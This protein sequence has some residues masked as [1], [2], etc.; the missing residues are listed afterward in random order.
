[1]STYKTR[2]NSWRN[3]LYVGMRWGNL[4]LVSTTVIIHKSPKGIH[5]PYLLVKDSDNN[6]REIQW[7]SLRAGYS[8]GKRTK[9]GASEYVLD[10]PTKENKHLRFT[11]HCIRSRCHNPKSTHY[12][13]YGG[14]GIHLQQEWQNNPNPFITYIKSLEGYGTRGLTLDRINNDRGYEV[15]NLRWTTPREQVLNRRVTIK[16]EYQKQ[17]M[18]LKIWHECY[19]SHLSYASVYKLYRKYNY[20]LDEILEHKIYQRK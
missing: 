1:M 18:P 10:N 2:S 6:I 20:T 4:E 16:V 12:S 5:V 7:H 15:G 8:T 3:D 14:R 17:I 19:A 13:N 11:W 9:K